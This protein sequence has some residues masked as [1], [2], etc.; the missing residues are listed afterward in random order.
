MYLTQIQILPNPADFIRA[1]AD[2]ADYRGRLNAKYLCEWIVKERLVG[3]EVEESDAVLV[4]RQ[5][6]LGALLGLGL[7]TDREE[8]GAKQRPRGQDFEHLEQNRG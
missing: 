7:P 5:D 1:Y 4:E 8:A 3:D 2:I 6:V